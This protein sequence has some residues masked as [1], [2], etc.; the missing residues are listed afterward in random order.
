MFYFVDSAV[1]LGAVDGVLIQ[2]HELIREDSKDITFQNKLV[3]TRAVIQG[4]SF[5]RALL[6]RKG[7]L[8]RVVILD[9]D[10]MF[11]GTLQVLVDNLSFTVR[12]SLYYRWRSFWNLIW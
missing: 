9:G 1:T 12:F 4:S 7:N 11:E 5:N 3:D 8:H 10:D 2:F 6:F